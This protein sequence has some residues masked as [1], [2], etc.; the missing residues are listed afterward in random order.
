VCTP[1]LRFF[2]VHLQDEIRFV[3]RDEGTTEPRLDRAPQVGTG[4]ASPARPIL[5]FHEG[6]S[7]IGLCEGF[8]GGSDERQ[9][10]RPHESHRT[11]IPAHRLGRLRATLV[12]SLDL[13][14]GSKTAIHT[15]AVS[16]IPA[17][18]PGKLP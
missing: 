5:A 11:T 13:A 7:R 1:D 10:E 18:R 3:R 17:S 16:E 9:H 4:E 15:P 6:D 2:E 14:A 8:G 12:G